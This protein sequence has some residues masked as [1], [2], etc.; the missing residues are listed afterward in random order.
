MNFGRHADVIYGTAA[1]I[2]G[3]ALVVVCVLFQRRGVLHWTELVFLGLCIGLQETFLR[4]HSLRAY[5]TGMLVAYSLLPLVLIGLRAGDIMAYRGKFVPLILETPLPLVFVSVQIMVLYL[6]EAPRLTSVVLVLALFSTVIGVRRQ[7]GDAVWPWLGVI[8][9][10]SAAYLLLQ[11]PGM[12]LS[13][14]LAS[15]QGRPTAQTAGARPASV[16]RPGFA[17]VTP[18]LVAATVVVACALFI[19]LPRPRLRADDPA[20]A[21]NSQGAP[22]MQ[23]GPGRGGRPPTGT[24]GPPGGEDVQLSGL[25]AGVSLGD[26]GRIQLDRRDA[27]KL[28]PLDNILPRAGV[29]Y[30][31]VYT[32]AEFDGTRWMPLPEDEAGIAEV[33]EGERREL[34][35]AP[36]VTGRGFTPHRYEVQLLEGARGSGG[37]LPLP[38]E[39]RA[40]RDLAGPL[41]YGAGD[42]QLRA[43]PSRAAVTYVADCVEPTAGPA[44]LQ[45]ALAGRRAFSAGVNPRLL[46]RPA[47]IEEKIRA[48]MQY[49]ANG[50][51]VSLYDELRNRAIAANTR[52]HI[53]RRGA[54]AA[55]ARIV[56]LFHE[57]RM[58]GDPAWTY[59]LDFRP[60]PGPDA[61]VRFLDL[62]SRGE[63]FGHCE[64]YASAMVVLLRCFGIPAR[65]CAGFAARKH[66]LDGVYHVTFANAHA[67]VD[68]WLPEHGWVTF[69]PTPP[70]EQGNPQPQPETP[71]PETPVAAAPPPVE[72]PGP[73]PDQWF[74][75]FSGLDPDQ[76]MQSLK[77]GLDGVLAGIE[78]LLARL[79][80]W[81]PAWVPENVWL[82]AA[83]LFS[84]FS[85]VLLHHLLFSRRR[86]RQVER[87]IGQ[88]DG[89]RKRER[90][91]YAQLLLLLSRHGYHKVAS[92]TPLEFAR[93]VRHKGG[94][95]HEP[96]EEL[97]RLYYGFRYG[98][99]EPL[100]E[101]FKRA[102][103]SYAA[104][105]KQA[106][107]AA[108]AQ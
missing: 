65:L 13:T 72:P 15:L 57:M 8:C 64:Y 33:P 23:T 42:H 18:A 95:V 39:T 68:A 29:I 60:L 37:E 1:R 69:D 46:S 45:A 5:R 17:L 67:W 62:S 25:G 93:R 6:R 76:W 73:D 11:H 70:H 79:T 104:R 47:G 12:L 100:V 103:S 101:D 56:Q 77:A 20:V 54:Y 4:L 35:G 107:G 21:A 63:R 59:S 91:L 74:E 30:L 81:M 40:V 44:E 50:Q 49:N 106:G 32:F 22:G 84:P 36:V 80:A 75:S 16:L 58:D 85:L 108:A 27:L 14:L 10:C 87:L 2:A 94:A 99:R 53:Q 48:V 88:A 97:T 96:V 82:R 105:L 55:C 34:A 26:F 43:L 90:G 83:I 52:D 19:L 31:R 41:R 86:R 24:S 71:E 102:L 7:V 78:G 66:D 98:S 38:K 28:K 51:P 9:A 89:T 3:L 61:I 92:E